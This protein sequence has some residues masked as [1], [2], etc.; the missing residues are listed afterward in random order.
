MVTGLNPGWSVLLCVLITLRFLP[1]IRSDFLHGCAQIFVLPWIMEFQGE[2]RVTPCA[3]VVDFYHGV[4]W[5]LGESL[6]LLCEK[7]VHGPRSTAHGLCGAKR[8]GFS[9]LRKGHFVDVY[10]L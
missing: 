10:V 9:L 8:N 1:Q 2:F 3:S 6:C 5:S 4:A 7:T